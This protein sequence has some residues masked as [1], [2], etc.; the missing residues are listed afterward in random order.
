MPTLDWIGKS[1]VL[2]HHRKVP[3]RLLRCSGELSAGDVDAGNLLVEGDNLLALKSLLPYYAG[4]VKCVYIDPPYNTGNEGWMYNDAVNSPEI[5]RWLGKVVGAELEDLSR[6]DKW[7]CMMY[8][9][10]SLL[11]EFLTEDGAIFISID[12]NE[13]H[14]LRLLMDEIFGAG[15]FIATIA[16]QKI[17]TVK[18]SA[19]HFSEMHDYLIVYANNSN[20]WKPNLLSRSEKQDSAYTNPDKDPRGPWKATPI[21]ARNHYSQGLYPIECPSG[22]VIAGPP[23]GTYWRMPENRFKAL[24][25]DNRIWWGRDGN[26]IPSQKRFLSEVKQGVVPATMW[27]YQEAGHNAEAKNELRAILGNSKDFFLTPKPTRLLRLIL[28]IAADKNSLIL[29]S[30]A[31]SGTTAHAALEANK[32]DGG[33]RRFILVEMDKNICRNVTAQRLTKVINGYTS[34]KSEDARPKEITGLGGGFKFCS[35]GEPLFDEV[36]NIREAVTFSDLAAHI[37]FT[38]TGT[39]LPKRAT[40]KTPLIGFHNGKA[41]YLLY[42]GV[43]G[44]ASSDGGNVL[45]KEVLGKMPAHDGVRVI[46]GESSRVKKSEL[47]RANVVFKQIPYEIKVS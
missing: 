5:R 25:A 20:K 45:T 47:I 30:F 36:G 35:L 19:R 17:Y 39:P 23:G 40:G 29:D 22:R 34:N 11:R 43:M 14:H 21:H 32:L 28:D 12:D 42:G 1:A 38:E 8:P 6:H 9:R 15:N 13:V 7:L 4:K 44:D 26:G 27:F 46:Y 41:V 18:N 10:L 24:D 31:G 33:R 2:N 3:Y 16:W 37:F